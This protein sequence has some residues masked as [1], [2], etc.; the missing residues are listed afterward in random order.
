MFRLVPLKSSTWL[1]FFSSEATN[2]KYALFNK[3]YDK[4]SK[5]NN[6]KQ[7]ESSR[8]IVFYDG[9]CDI[10]VSEI[11]HYKS[12]I[13]TK[14]NVTIAFFDLTESPEDTINILQGFGIP[15]QSPYKRVH[16]I[17]END[18]SAFV[19]TKAFCEIWLRVP[20]WNHIVPFVR[21]VPGIMTLSDLIYGAIAETRLKLVPSHP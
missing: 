1:R 9:K 5:P 2:S 8:I 12:L 10:C 11:N 18:L 3:Y 17:T 19:S 4:F 21:G 13:A 14:E 20:Y 16:V 15:L 6:N 7:K